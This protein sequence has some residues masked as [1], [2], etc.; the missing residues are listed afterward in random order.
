M[1]KLFSS[2]VWLV[3]ATLIYPAISG[4]LLGRIKLMMVIVIKPKFDN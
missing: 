2:L 3:L 4:K 1:E